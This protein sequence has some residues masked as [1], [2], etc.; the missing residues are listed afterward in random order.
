MFDGPDRLQ[1]LL[2]ACH[3]ASTEISESSSAM[4]A[5]HV[6]ER[7]AAFNQMLTSTPFHGTHS[8]K[9]VLQRHQCNSAGQAC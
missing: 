5:L 2:K 4:S 9:L 3:L 1:H 6:G 8:A 7:R